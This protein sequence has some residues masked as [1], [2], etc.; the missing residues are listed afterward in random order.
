ML[1]IADAGTRASNG[2]VSGSAARSDSA[3]KSSAAIKATAAAERGRGILVQDVNV[4]LGG[5]PVLRNTCVSAE[6]GRT[7][8]LLGPSGCGK[9]T[10]LRVLS[11]LQRLDSGCVILGDRVMSAP[12]MHESPNK[13]GVG[14]VFQDWSLFPH[15]SVAAN[16]AF[17]LPRS[18][19]PR[20]YP[21][22]R[23][24]SQRV[25]DLLEMVG[26]TDLAQRMPG[27][28]SGGQQQRVALARALAPAPTVLLLDEPFS[29]LDTTLRVDVRA[30]VAALLKELAVTCVFVTHDQDEAFVLGDEVAVMRDGAV[31]QQASPARIYE[32]P[33]DRWL[34]GFVGEADT[35]AGQA[36]GD[37]AYTVLGPV[38]LSTPMHGEVDVLLRP[39]ELV[40]NDDRLA[41]GSATSDNFGIVDHVEFF[42]HDTLYYV[43]DTHSGA[44]LRC[45]DSGAPRFGV[46]ANVELF[47]SGVPTV[48]FKRHC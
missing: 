22:A 16:V 12:G 40:M 28:L 35:V 24:A 46:G 4:A 30:E 39:E 41:A 6:A 48:A 5:A 21:L 1:D 33:A 7:L 11:G 43:R 31:V 19:R 32:Q 36:Q 27:S 29:S 9:T 10:L 18:Q 38:K 47:H 2:V 25:D 14:M 44:V 42:G 3:S 23:S 34:A 45:R 15:L 17:G 37:I 13:R 20:R 26:V 8:A